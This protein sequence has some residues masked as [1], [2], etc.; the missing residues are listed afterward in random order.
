[1]NQVS[2]VLYL[3]LWSLSSHAKMQLPPTLAEVRETNYYAQLMKEHPWLAKY[4]GNFESYHNNAM[5]IIRQIESLP[6]GPEAIANRPD[7][8]SFEIQMVVSA[9]ARIYKLNP[10]YSDLLYSEK[11]K[12][13]IDDTNNLELVAKVAKRAGHFQGALTGVLSLV[14]RSEAKKVFALGDQEQQLNAVLSLLDSVSDESIAAHFDISGYDSLITQA[15]DRKSLKHLLQKLFEE[16]QA[17]RLIVLSHYLNSLGGDFEQQKRNFSFSNP[18][19]FKN[20]IQTY[21]RFYIPDQSRILDSIVRQSFERIEA[22]QAAEEIVSR[23]QI[24]ELACFPALFRGELGGDCSTSHSWP[25]PLSPFDRIFSVTVNDKEV[26]YVGGTMVHVHGEPTFYLRD[27]ASCNLNARHIEQIWAGFYHA[28]KLLGVDH[29]ILANPKKLHDVNNTPDF[30]TEIHKWYVED[31]ESSEIDY[32]PLDR[33]IRE[34]ILAGFAQTSGYDSAT[35]NPNGIMMRERP[36]VLAQYRIEQIENKKL[37]NKPIE[38]LSKQNLYDLLLRGLNGDSTALLEV[39]QEER[40]AYIH[41][42]KGLLNAGEDPLDDFYQDVGS[43]LEPFNIQ[44][45]QKLVH[46]WQAIFHFGH[47]MAQDALSIR[48]NSPWHKLTVDFVIAMIMRSPRAEIAYRTIERNPDLFKQSEKFKSMVEALLT[49]HG[50]ADALDEVAS[51]R[52]GKIINSGID[53]SEMFDLSLEQ[54]E[55][56]RNSSFGSLYNTQ[57]IEKKIASYIENP[58]QDMDA[59]IFYGETAKNKANEILDNEDKYSARTIVA[60]IITR[61]WYL[62]NIGDRLPEYI[63]NL[64]LLKEWSSREE[65]SPELRSYIDRKFHY[66]FTARLR[67][68]QQQ[69]CE[70]KLLSANQAPTP[71]SYSKDNHWGVI[72]YKP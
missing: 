37:D 29:I 62:E 60:A 72:W 55:V 8:I 15:P 30:Q 41:L 70:E 1:M 42:H 33:L 6:G 11:V 51:A 61:L 34:Q 20:E 45:S 7:L 32:D 52:L 66:Q 57:Y 67:T 47:L 63:R 4:N 39:S 59:R 10:Q 58:I 16:E 28:R 69:S 25:Y 35:G 50:N 31:R 71:M 5:M 40:A 36:E 12:K 46:D 26:G 38:K 2:I 24:R 3:F 19:D 54:H 65:I 68:V 64:K 21:M 22:K 44:L 48:G 23:I 43:R 9:D 27:V 18:E 13:I 14:E 17:A 49:P 53:L 56:L